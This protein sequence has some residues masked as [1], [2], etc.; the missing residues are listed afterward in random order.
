MYVVKACD[1]SIYLPRFDTPASLQRQKAVSAMP[2][3]PLQTQ[4]A[5]SNILPFGSVELF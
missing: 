1:S 3:V 4:M 5:V 2:V